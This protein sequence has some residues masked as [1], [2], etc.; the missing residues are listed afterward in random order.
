ME[1]GMKHREKSAGIRETISQS[2]TYDTK[3]NI[4]N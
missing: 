4:L 2:I 1:E 3:S